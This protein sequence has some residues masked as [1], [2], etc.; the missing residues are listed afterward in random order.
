MIYAHTH[1]FDYSQTTLEI[2]C[3]QTHA[4]LYC[5][6]PVCVGQYICLF[7]YMSVHRVYASVMYIRI[8]ITT[9]YLFSADVCNLR[10][11]LVHICILVFLI[12][13]NS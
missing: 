11:H 8:P 6:W 1:R 5:M 13:N 3:S 4:I 12:R 2:G 10:L 7:L 9:V